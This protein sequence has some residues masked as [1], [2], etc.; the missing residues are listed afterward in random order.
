MY[1]GARGPTRTV[2]RHKPS[3]QATPPI[4]LFISGKR[5]NWQLQVE[6]DAFTRRPGSIL[7]VELKFWLNGLY[8]Q[9][10]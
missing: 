5:A 2:F 6:R 8:P 4:G 10:F 1:R 9:I 7:G 3:A